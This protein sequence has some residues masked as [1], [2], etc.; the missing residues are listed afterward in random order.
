MK[1]E[2][3]KNTSK[4]TLDLFQTFYAAHNHENKVIFVL[5]KSEKVSSNFLIYGIKIFFH[6][7]KKRYNDE[8]STYL[9]L[10]FDS[11]LITNIWH[12]KRKVLS[13]RVVPSCKHINARLESL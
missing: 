7:L 9:V 2:I 13:G 6:L 3:L 12:W 1:I 4:P 10:K 11:H 8:S 5:A